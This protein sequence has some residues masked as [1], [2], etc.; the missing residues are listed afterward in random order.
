MRSAAAFVI[1]GLLIGTGGST[2]A[3]E[4]LLFDFGD[5]E[6]VAR[7][8]TI[9]DVVMGGVSSGSIETTEDGTVLFTGRVSLENNGGFASIRSLPRRVDLGAYS[10]IEIRVRGDGQRY[11]LHLRTDSSSDRLVYRLPFETSDGEW[12]TLRLP[13]GRFE[14]SVRGRIV[15]DAPPFDPERM[16]SVGVLISDKQS[17][18][19]RLEIA[20]IAAY[21]D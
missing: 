1:S 2:M 20:W 12:Q 18:P 8:T 14:P 16:T 10:G 4:E 3:G 9:H 15:P 21:T 5:P 19:F 13:F 6:A 17:G 11:K 7:W